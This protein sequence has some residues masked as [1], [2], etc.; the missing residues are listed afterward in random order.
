MKRAKPA[1]KNLVE[2]GGNNIDGLVVGDV[3]KVGSSEALE[4][5]AA[6]E[7]EQDR[8]AHDGTRKSSQDRQDGGA[9]KRRW[10]SNSRHWPGRGEKGRLCRKLSF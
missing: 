1:T 3:E 5:R 9:P 2:I 8:E 6:R 10:C 7:S 4:V